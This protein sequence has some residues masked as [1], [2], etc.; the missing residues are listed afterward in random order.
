[1][2]VGVISFGITHWT[3]KQQ[4]LS[5]PAA[6]INVLQLAYVLPVLGIIFFWLRPHFSNE[7]WLAV[8]A[9]LAVAVTFYA[10]AT[11]LMVLA[12][13][14]QL[15]IAYSALE[16]LRVVLFGPAQFKPAWYMA[17]VPAAALVGLSFVMVQRLRGQATGAKEQWLAPIGLIYRC[18][19]VALSI[20]WIFRYISEEHFVWVFAL[21]GAACFGGTLF[22]KSRELLAI[23]AVYTAF[24]FLILWSRFGDPDAIYWPNLC[25]IFA[26][27][28]QQA[29]AQ[30]RKDQFQIPNGLHTLV[31]LLGLTSLWFW[32]SKWVA[33]QAG[34]FYLTATWAGLALAIFA[35]GFALKEKVYRW[36]GLAILTC[37]LCRVA[38]LDIWRLE[39]I[40]RILSFMALGI[41]LLVLGFVYNRY[42]EKIRQ[43]L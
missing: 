43:W 34:G 10:L 19:A 3:R 38:V 20:L 18:V 37:A 33:Q 30:R 28:G 31:I 7:T 1:V 41:V 21:A 11:R 35:A 17:L 23:S 26:L 36:S 40:Y 6:Q 9:G 5:I 27:L 25:V 42:Q 29:I 39:T 32:I 13:A 12:I 4:R 22:I 24:A 8:T 14:G 2:V 16:F 15:Y